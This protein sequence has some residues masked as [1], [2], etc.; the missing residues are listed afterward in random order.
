MRLS[1]AY[2][3]E[4]LK[5][6]FGLKKW[7]GISGSDG[8]F[9]P[10]L[11]ERGRKVPEN[12]VCIASRRELTGSR[13]RGNRRET[14]KLLL[15]ITGWKDQGQEN[16]RFLR[17]PYLCLEA[18]CSPS[19]V[20][21]Y[22]QEVYDLCDE[23]RE[24]LHRLQMKHAGVQEA[25]QLSQKLFGNPLTVMGIDFSLVAEAG[26]EGLSPGA[27]LFTDGN[28]N[29]DYMNAFIQDENYKGLLDAQGP[30]VVPAYINGCRS[31]NMNLRAEGRV[32]HHLIL[33][34]VW[35]PLSEADQCLLTELANCL[36][37]L[38]I[39]APSVLEE[40]D[41][42]DVFR[43]L[44]TDRTADYMAVSR[45]LSALGWSPDH[46]YLCLVLQTSF[47]DQ[48][49]VTIHAI[50]K[51]I[52]KQFPDS[53]SFQMQEEIIIFLNLTRLGLTEEEAEGALTV[54]IRDSFLK[55]GYSRLLRGHMNLRRQYLQ[56]K[57]ALEVGERRKPHLW[58]HRFNQVVVYYILEQITGKLPA[59]MLAHEKLLELKRQDEL[60]QSELV[61]TL[62]TYLRQ[63]LNATQT[64]NEL[65]IHRSTFLYRLEKIKTVLQTNLEDP[66][67]IFY[68][69]LS[70]RL[71]EL[72]EK[73]R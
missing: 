68:L 65:F 46:D 1:G 67:E 3:A 42:E 49:M 58:I 5:K 41:L 24:Q 31:M 36:E 13:G 43:T 20:L 17:S 6:E 35:Q 9:R 53:S 62:K 27:R 47:L 44:L 29:L 11:M 25:L 34:E 28:I 33:T 52:K 15:V 38:L 54:F 48:K 64:A 72:E 55:A 71:L 12:H 59:S 40:D 14:E 8:Y 37:Y 73:K 26:T 2:L 39:H 4:K 21:N 56:A 22:L 45:R 32:T 23:W 51:Y 19:E 30:I 57:I 63:N 50:C 66:D 60:H 18:E 70:V 16:D 61:L 7:D 10:F 69:N